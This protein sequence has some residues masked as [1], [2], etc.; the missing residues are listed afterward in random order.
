MRLASLEHLNITASA[1]AAAF[2]PRGVIRLPMYLLPQQELPCLGIFGPFFSL[3]TFLSSVPAPGAQGC[4]L[5][6]L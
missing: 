2:H 6:W 4:K 1:A 3:S 5:V